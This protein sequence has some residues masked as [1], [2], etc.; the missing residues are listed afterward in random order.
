MD[1]K[2]L[3]FKI[4][5]KIELLIS[6]KK[7]SKS[8]F[9]NLSALHISLLI[10]ALGMVIRDGMEGRG[11]V[12]IPRLGNFIDRGKKRGILLKMIGN[13]T[14]RKK[15]KVP[16][17]IL[18]RLVDIGKSGTME[19]ISQILLVNELLMCD[20]TD[21]Q[22]RAI[23]EPFWNSLDRDKMGI[24]QVATN[25]GIGEIYLKDLYSLYADS[26]DCYPYGHKWKRYTSVKSIREHYNIGVIDIINSGFKDELMSLIRIIDESK[27]ASDV[28]YIDILNYK[29]INYKE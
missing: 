29:K 26:R 12:S 7:Y 21:K 24:L 25:I 3:A 5:E 20:L 6:D 16:E 17:D 8:S 19:Q 13:R 22:H 10:D 15:R 11:A 1:T 27:L 18:S 4:S 23:F 2:E 28:W 9:P 14:V